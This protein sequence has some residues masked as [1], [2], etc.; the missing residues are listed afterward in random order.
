MSLIGYYVILSFLDSVWLLQ[1]KF[2]DVRNFIF[3]MSKIYN[4]V[5]V[6]IL[7]FV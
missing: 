5:G 1:R 2:G 3:D 4:K 6:F 7:I